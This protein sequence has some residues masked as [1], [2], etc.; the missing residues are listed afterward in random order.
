MNKFI[1]KLTLICFCFSMLSMTMAAPVPYVLASG[2]TLE[3]K[4]LNKSEMDTKQTIAL[5]MVPGS[6]D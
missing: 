4:V 5:L 3:I 6:E 2:D 1:I